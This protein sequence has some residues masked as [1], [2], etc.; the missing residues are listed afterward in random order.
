NVTKDEGLVNFSYNIMILELRSNV[1]DGVLDAYFYFGC[2]FSGFSKGSF[3]QAAGFN[4]V[5]EK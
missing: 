2:Y 1:T 5:D 4:Y 3:F